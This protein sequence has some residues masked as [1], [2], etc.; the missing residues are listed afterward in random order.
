MPDPDSAGPEIVGGT[1]VNACTAGETFDLSSGENG[2]CVPCAGGDGSALSVGTY[3]T[4]VGTDACTLCANPRNAS[5]PGATAAEQCRCMHGTIGL[6]EEQVLRIASIGA[7]TATQTFELSDQDF[8]NT[9]VVMT[10]LTVTSTNFR[11]TLHRYGAS[12][13]IAECASNC[14]AAFDLTQF[15]PVHATLTVQGTCTLTAYTHIGLTFAFD[16]TWLTPS[17]R[18]EAEQL[19]VQHHLTAGAIIIKPD[20]PYSTLV[21]CISCPVG[22]VCALQS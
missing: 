1:C 5:L 3:K 6:D 18:T 4:T 13:L 14:P 20:E 8:I 11:A 16:P 2:A 21:Q 19:A 12:L 7:P 9:Q 17:L 22:V 10:S 15:N